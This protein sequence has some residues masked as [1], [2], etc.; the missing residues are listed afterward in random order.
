MADKMSMKEYIDSFTGNPVK[1]SNKK[2]PHEEQR[3]KIIA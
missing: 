2:A 1:R 3:V